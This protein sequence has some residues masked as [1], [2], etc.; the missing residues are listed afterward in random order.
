MPSIKEDDAMIKG[1]IILVALAAAV[2]GAILAY[3]VRASREAGRAAT[4]R[5]TPVQTV[6]ALPARMQAWQPNMDLVG[7]LHASRG[8]DLALQVA[9]IVEFIAFESGE[10]VQEGALLLRLNADD[11][12]AKLAALKAT[13]TFNAVTLKRDME[14]LKIRAVS[15]A[16]VDAD[17]AG[18][19]NAEALVAE[20]Q[21]LVAQYS[22]KAPFAGRLGIREA[23]LGQ[24]LDAGTT[25][26]SLQA[27]DPIFADFHVPQQYFGQL[28]AGLPVEV[29]VNTYPGEVFP[30]TV[31]AVNPK[32]EAGNRNVRVRATLQNPD[33][34]LVPGMFVNI[35]LT[36]GAAE[37][38]VTL[39]QTAIVAN[40][41]GSTVFVVEQA[42]DGGPA[43]ARETFVKTGATRGDLVAVVSG[44]K[45][46]ETVVIAGQIKLRNGTPVAIDN[47]HVPVAA[48]EPDVAD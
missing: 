38:V 44:L 34:R 8:A 26:V 31:S 42:A 1:R 39:P 29:R 5:G 45:E 19:R 24:Y 27:L 2:I 40:P 15:Q 7:Q 25:I 10:T 21:A 17:E 28:K 33:G 18:L 22:L 41:Y 9:G 14:Q 32:V 13:A 36:M 6:A 11:Q 23:D 48:T 37:Q 4:G 46:G 3:H 47:A 30:G 20:Q 16:T 43:I 35:S 12:I